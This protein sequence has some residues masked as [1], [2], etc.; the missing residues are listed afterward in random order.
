AFQAVAA[1]AATT[2][3]YGTYAVTAGGTWTYTL[4]NSNGAVEALNGSQTLSDSFAVLTEDGTSRTVTITINAANDAAVVGG[5]SSGTVIEAGGVN[6][7]T[8]GT[9]TATGALTD[10][11]VD[12]A[13]NTFQAVAAGAASAHGYGTYAV[14]AGGA[15]TY[16]L[17]NS[18]GAVE[19]LNGSQTLSD[20]FAVLTEDGTSRTVTIT[21]N[22]A[23]DAAVVGGTSTGTVIE[24]GGVNNGTPGTPTASGALTH[25]DVD[26]APNTFQAVAAGA[27]SAHGY[28]TYA[29][30]AGGTWTYTLNNSHASVEALNGSQTLSDSF[31]VLTEDGTSRTVSITINATNDAAV[32]A[33]TSTGTV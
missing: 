4:N 20:S 29:V 7:G 13:P 5:T 3:G 18:N 21:I 19:A 8:P 30:T 16:T 28:G 15:W 32:L 6:N 23:N 33:G 9:P 24:A 14:T 10:S 26:N 31:A 27:A 11:D 25:S 12:N 22:A 1:G 17:N 2:H